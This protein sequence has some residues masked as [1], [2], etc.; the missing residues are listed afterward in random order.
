MIEKRTH[1]VDHLRIHRIIKIGCFK[2]LKSVNKNT[3]T[4]QANKS[5][6]NRLSSRK[7]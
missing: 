5:E 3:T 1:N 6:I 7:F 2:A 4:K